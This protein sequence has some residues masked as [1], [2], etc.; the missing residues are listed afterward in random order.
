MKLSKNEK[1]LIEIFIKENKKIT[2]K[3]ISEKM[4][5]S[6]KTVYRIIKKINSLSVVGEVIESYI[7]TG[8]VL[9]YSNYLKLDSLEFDGVNDVEERVKTVL[10]ELLFRAPRKVKT[11]YLYKDYFIADETIYSDVERIKKIICPYELKI[12]KEN[13]YLRIAGTEKNIRNLSYSLVVSSSILD[14]ESYSIN[15]DELNQ[16]DADFLTRQLETIEK[17]LGGTLLYPHNI[18]I[19]SHLY[20]LLSRYRKGSIQFS[21]ENINLP[22][23][24]IEK[25]LIEN[26]ERHYEIA[27]K[28]LNNINLYLSATIDEMEAFYLFQYIISARI[29][30]KIDSLD[31]DFTKR[32]FD[33]CITYMSTNV[34]SDFS[35]LQEDE[36]FLSH[37]HLMLYRGRNEILIKN[38]LLDDIRREYSS[39]FKYLEKFSEAV[40]EKY[41]DVQISKDE[42]G[43]LV[44]YFAKAFEQNN[45]KKRVIIMCSSGVGTSELLKVKVGRYFPDLEIVDVVSMNQYRKKYETLESIDVDFIL[46]TVIQ[47]EIK[48]TVPVIL[49]SAMFTKQDQ[50]YVSKIMEGY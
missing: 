4:A 27:K 44:L 31:Y 22:L 37:F 11:A 5:I 6:T 10:L 26:N 36:N 1:A 21:D 18:N 24:N 39:L 13:Q 47:K 32:V 8:L 45:V 28:I 49:V 33:Q 14:K 34:S 35:S 19:F 46:S 15:D 43:F 12:Y 41:K 40:S 16:Y 25:N 9:N 17:S 20:I 38:E 50:E 2:A 29:N 7:G 42:I 23:D 30:T 48:S 3:E